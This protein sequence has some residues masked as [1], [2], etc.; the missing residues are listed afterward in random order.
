MKIQ[1]QVNRSGDTIGWCHW[2]E[3]CES[4]HCFR[5]EH[6]Q[7]EGRPTWKFD[8]SVETPSFHPSMRLFTGPKNSP[9]TI[10]HYFVKAGRIEYCEDSPH[11]LRGQKRELLDVDVVLADRAYRYQYEERVADRLRALIQLDLEWARKVMPGESAD[12]VRLVAM[13][14]SRYENDQVPREFRIESGAWLLER[15]LLRANLH[16]VLPD[17][18]LP[19]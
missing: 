12:D 13:H 3:A 5:I 10:C 1:P 15:G 4:L 18:K 2:C 14:R 8:G 6:P 9:K 19:K 16:P 17:G 11:R 7:N